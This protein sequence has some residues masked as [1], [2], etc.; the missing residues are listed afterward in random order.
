MALAGIARLGT[1]PHVTLFPSA[2][3]PG[4][5]LRP[6]PAFLVAIADSKGGNGNLAVPFQASVR[7]AAAL[8]VTCRG[9]MGRPSKSGWGDVTNGGH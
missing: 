8:V 2:G 9:R 6:V 3:E 1:L 4:G 7:P 5:V